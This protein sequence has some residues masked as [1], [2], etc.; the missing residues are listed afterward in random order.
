VIDEKLSDGSRWARGLAVVGDASACA[1]FIAINEQIEALEVGKTHNFLNAK[2][3]MY[4]GWMRLE[5]DEWG[6]ITHSND[7]VTPNT[8]KN[9]SNIEY[10][11][12]GSEDDE[13]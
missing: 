9:V 10:E 12:V 6:A 5:V 11:L 8:K 1:V 3:V 13:D 4:K 7:E 2:V